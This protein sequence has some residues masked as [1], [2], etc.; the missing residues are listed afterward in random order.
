MSLIEVAAG[1]V[2]MGTLLVS[3]L[4]ANARLTAQS[5][6]AD[7]GLE[8]TRI[9]DDLLEKLWDKRSDFPRD[10]EGA[11]DG[12]DRWTW[13]TKTVGRLECEPTR[14]DVV[15]LEVFGPDRDKNKNIPSAHV[16]IMLPEKGNE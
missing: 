4:L 9:A 2:L 12:H 3:I 11:V 8:A 10:A 1:T 5:I 16:E 6:R 14:A 15:A 13:R 7:S